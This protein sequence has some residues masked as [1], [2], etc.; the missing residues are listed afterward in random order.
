MAWLDNYVDGWKLDEASGNALSISGTNDFTD[1][2]TVGSGTGKIN[3]ARDFEAGSLEYFSLEDNAALSFGDEGCTFALWINAESLDT[4][5]TLF[6]KDD[7]TTRE[8]AL[9][10][11]VVTGKFSFFVTS[12]GT[13]GTLSE[14][15]T[16]AASF[17]TATWYLAICTHD[18][19]A[20]EIA[21]SINAGTPDT[22]SHSGG[23]F[24]GTVDFLLGSGPGTYWD[25]LI[26]EFHVWR[27]V[28]TSDER[29]QLY[30]GGSG[31][32]YPFTTNAVIPVYMRQYR[33]RWAA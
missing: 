22:A 26:D 9:Y 33:Q 2:N 11:D 8:Y 29:T 14:V 12:D 4:F 17:S 6:S 3:N 25:G 5:R 1:N 31:L 28:L 20:N 7:F 23:I 10:Y 21:I 18:A 19:A 24:D 27:R 32:A 16:T 15:K 30:N 13:N